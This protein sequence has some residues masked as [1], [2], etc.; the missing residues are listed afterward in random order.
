MEHPRGRI[1]L[2]FF[3]CI[4]DHKNFNLFGF[5]GPVTGRAVLFFMV[6]FLWIM[7]VFSGIGRAPFPVFYFENS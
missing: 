3:D 7:F 6:L 4:I 2:L 1:A 5:G